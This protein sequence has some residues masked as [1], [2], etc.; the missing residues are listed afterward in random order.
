VEFALVLTLLTVPMMSI[1]DV[2]VYVYD[3]MQ[4]ENAAQVAS[5]SVWATCTNNST[6][7]V[8][9]NCSSAQTAISNAAKTTSLG[10]NVSVTAT[11]EGW[12]CVNGSGV[13]TQVGS[14]GTF[15]SPLSPT[16]APSC[17]AGTWTNGA[18]AADYAA[19]TV[20][21]TYAPIFGGISVA[22]LFGTSITK[23]AWIPIH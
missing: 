19:V 16:S 7:P 12:Y 9:D 18:N 13:L 15:A 3:K 8:T 5:Q 10:T 20:A 14:T 17:G 1:V 21:Y 22:T 11:T 2:G 4:V 6:W 23:T